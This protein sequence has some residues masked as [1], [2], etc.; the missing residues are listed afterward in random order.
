MRVLAVATICCC[1]PVCF[2]HLRN[3]RIDRPI[4]TS[5]PRP[6]LWNLSVHLSSLSKLAS[7]IGGK[8]RI[9]RLVAAG[10]RSGV[11]KT[12]P[13]ESWMKTIVQSV[14]IGEHAV[15]IRT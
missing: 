8:P 14:A 2:R 5:S 12:A 15:T 9:L 7:K 4:S 3:R 1:L 13:V 10:E 11:M 6:Y